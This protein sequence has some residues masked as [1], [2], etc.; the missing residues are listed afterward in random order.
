MTVLAPRYSKEV[1]AQRG[2][3]I[4]ERDIRPHLDAGDDG[5]FVAIDIETG[6]Y[7]IDRDDYTAT[8]R[9]LRRHP[10]AQMWLLRVGQRTAYRLGGR[11]SVRRYDHRGGECL[12][13]S[14]DRLARTGC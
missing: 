12:Y 9:L 10:H 3:T 4:Y 5:K 8:D 14:N 13:R 1:F 7:E 2:Q 6:A 11:P